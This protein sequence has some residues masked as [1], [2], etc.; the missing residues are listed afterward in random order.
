[1]NSSQLVNSLLLLH[2]YMLYT[3]KPKKGPRLQ[4]LLIAV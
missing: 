1:M 3:K 2:L 4:A